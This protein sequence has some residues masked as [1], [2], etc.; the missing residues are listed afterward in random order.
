MHKSRFYLVAIVIVAALL[1]FV[2]LDVIPPS[3]TWDEAAWGY[4]AFSLGVDVKDEFGKNFPLDFIESFGDFKPPMY[5]YLGI[6]PVKIFG[7]NEFSTRFPSALFGVLSVITTYFFVLEIFGKQRRG[8]ALL[9]AFLLAISPWHIM[10]SRAA[11]E[12]NIAQFFILL[13][14]FLFLKSMRN[15]PYLLMGSVLSFVASM[16]TFNSARIVVPLVVI[17]MGLFFSRKILQQ[18]KTTAIALIVGFIVCLPLFLFLN[19]PQA[20]LRFNE[21]NIF[22]DSG[23]IIRANH[24]IENDNYTPISKIIHNRRLAYAVEYMRHYVDNL[25]PQFLFIRGDGN[26]KFSIQDVGQLYIWEIPFLI[27]GVLILFRKR[28]GIWWIVPVMILI[29][30]IP[31][32]FARETPHALRIENTLPAFQIL[33]ALG[34]LSFISIIPKN[35]KQIGIGLVSIVVLLNFVYFAHNY[36]TH[37]AREFSGEWQ[38]GYKES[39]EYVK[40][41]GSGYSDVYVTEALGRPYIYYLFYMKYDPVLFRSEAQIYREALGFVHVNKFSNIHFTSK[42]KDVVDVGALY[43]STPSEKPESAHILQEFRLLNGDVAL[44]AYTL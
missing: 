5:A 34:L 17:V 18:W 16:Y 42:I 26:P 31:A 35:K 7:L 2:Y 23:V 4:N 29:G 37:Y 14:I 21:V 41:Q 1:R 19:T 8:L 30:I 39:V 40:A 6:L 28:V 33:T 44:V 9:S 43:I 15:K 11:F 20:K 27:A 22:S 12:A 25:T 3:L 10:L 24:Q 13:G 38:Y 36:L 32:G